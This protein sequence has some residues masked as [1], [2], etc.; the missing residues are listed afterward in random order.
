MHHVHP[1]LYAFGPPSVLLCALG[2]ETTNHVEPSSLFRMGRPKGSAK[3][4]AAGVSLGVIPL[5]HFDGR[6]KFVL[7]SRAARA[8]SCESEWS[9]PKNW[10]EAPLAR[11]ETWLKTVKRRRGESL[12]SIL[13][14]AG[15]LFCHASAPAEAQ[16][17]MLKGR[18]FGSGH[19]QGTLDL[20]MLMGEP[21]FIVVRGV[22]D[23]A[24]CATLLDA[25]VSSFGAQRLWTRCMNA[26]GERALGKLAGEKVHARPGTRDR[27][28]LQ[29]LD[30][31]AIKNLDAA[32]DASWS[33]AVREVAREAG[34]Y[35][36]HSAD[37]ALN[38]C[39]HGMK[40]QDW[41]TDSSASL[42]YVVALTEASA[43]ELL[44]VDERWPDFAAS[45]AARREAFFSS[46]FATAATATDDAVKSANPKLRD[47]ATLQKLDRGGDRDRRR[48]QE[49][50]PEAAAGRRRLLLHEED[51]SRAAASADGRTAL[52]ALRSFLPSGRDQ[53]LAANRPRRLL[54]CVP[55]VR[56]FY[57]HMP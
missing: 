31:S 24:D 57:I 45:G 28:T 43:T 52:Y 42:A 4:L 12:D 19:W 7:A 6:T 15:S 49:R 5:S 37:E 27:A 36:D 46:A 8:D 17:S 50:Q 39:T 23:P 13:E 48:R 25:A 9:K 3:Q 44:Q 38:L 55:V 16:L 18:Q 14:H 29:K 10:T 2:D 20:D 33:N 22:V 41:H 32:V 51:P 11:L 21:G 30:R 47:G 40:R 35:A 26:H 53:L 56:Y 1:S 34:R 54:A